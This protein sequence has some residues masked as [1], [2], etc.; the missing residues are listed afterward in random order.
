MGSITSHQQPTTSPVNNNSSNFRS[1]KS[2]RIMDKLRRKSSADNHSIAID[3]ILFEFA[4]NPNEDPKLRPDDFGKQT[5][6]LNEIVIQLRDGEEST[7]TNQTE[8]GFSEGATHSQAE[9][10]K[11]NADR[12]AS[13]NSTAKFETSP[14]EALPQPRDYS[15][16]QLFSRVPN[17]NQPLLEDNNSSA[18]RGA[19]DNPP[20]EGI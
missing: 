20:E 10:T 19:E 9:S 16:D 6:G 13:H 15:A 14:E 5:L 17:N 4:Q 7:P 18:I 8:T 12:T 2:K 1:R 11:Q 3:P